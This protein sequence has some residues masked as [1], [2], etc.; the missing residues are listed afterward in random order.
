M[1]EKQLTPEEAEELRRKAAQASV[2][3]DVAV[4]VAAQ[5]KANETEARQDAKEQ[6]EQTLNAQ[7]DTMRASGREAVAREDA[8]EQREQTLNAQEDTMRASGRE[9]VARENAREQQS[10]AMSA[11]ASTVRALGREA[12]AEEVAEEQYA[13]AVSAQTD[14]A[15]MTTL[16]HMANERADIEES[17]GDRARFVL[18]L[19]GAVAVTALVVVVAWLFAR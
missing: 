12:D 2:E 19:I 1:D 5:A 17:S 7:A 6:R 13:E 8:R 18:L 9:A 4:R 10:E 3:R 16:R 15:H 11:Q 14:A